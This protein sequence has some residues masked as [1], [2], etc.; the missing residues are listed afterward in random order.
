VIPANNA[1]VS[2]GDLAETGASVLAPIGLAVG[3]IAVGIGVLWLQRRRTAH[4]R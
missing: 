2:S 4:S 3:L 1:N